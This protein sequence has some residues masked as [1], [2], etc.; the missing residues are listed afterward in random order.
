VPNRLPPAA[1]VYQAVLLP[2]DEVKVEVAPQLMVVVPVIT[3]CDTFEF[4]VTGTGTT[5]LA[6]EDDIEVIVTRP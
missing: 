1:A 3:G 4:T 5:A 6:Q 2:L